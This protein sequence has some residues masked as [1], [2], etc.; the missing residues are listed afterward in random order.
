MKWVKASPEI[1]T[2]VQGNEQGLTPALSRALPS[3]LSSVEEIDSEE[4]CAK[5]HSLRFVRRHV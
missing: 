2:L 1:T 5:L 4:V 3:W